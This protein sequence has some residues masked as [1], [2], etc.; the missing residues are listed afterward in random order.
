MRIPLN[1]PKFIENKNI[2]WEKKLQNENTRSSQKMILLV[3]Y[4]IV[5][6]IIER[7]FCLFAACS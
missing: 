7:V 4:D 1:E 6:F 2:Y 5:I 3:F